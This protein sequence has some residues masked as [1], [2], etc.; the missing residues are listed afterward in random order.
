MAVAHNIHSNLYID[1]NWYSK[2]QHSGAWHTAHLHLQVQ[3]SPLQTYK[4]AGLQNR[5][6]FIYN[7]KDQSLTLYL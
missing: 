3:S 4:Q 1:Q 5:L 6:H 7:S 2:Q